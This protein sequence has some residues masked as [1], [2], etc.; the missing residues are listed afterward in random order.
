MDKELV[1]FIINQ[2]SEVHTKLDNLSE[3]KA[4]KSDVRQLLDAVDEYA[5]KADTYFQE[6]VMLAHKID[7]HEKWLRQIAEKVGLN[8][9]S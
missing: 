8:L 6:M 4:D 9:E 1:D 2:F 3:N 5:R 7:R